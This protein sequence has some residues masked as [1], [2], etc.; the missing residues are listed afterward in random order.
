MKGCVQWNPVFSI[1]KKT[2]PPQARFEPYLAV[3]GLSPAGG[4]ILHTVKPI[5]C[6]LFFNVSFCQLN[7]TKILEWSNSVFLSIF[8]LPFVA[9]K[10]IV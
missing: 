2:T 4:G 10:F 6:T 3:L 9:L 1:E 7:M 8:P 5:P